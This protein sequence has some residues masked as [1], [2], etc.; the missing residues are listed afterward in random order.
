MYYLEEEKR[1]FYAEEDLYVPGH[2]EIDVDKNE[3]KEWLMSV[4]LRYFYKKAMKAT[5][6][7]LY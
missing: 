4:I 1:G 7:F 3:E 2:Y 5:I 6:I